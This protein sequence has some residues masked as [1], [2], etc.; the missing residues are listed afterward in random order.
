[1]LE[2][3]D[4]TAAPEESKEESKEETSVPVVEPEPGP[5]EPLPEPAQDGEVEAKTEVDE[6]KLCQ[7][8]EA[9]L[10]ASDHPLGSARLA[11]I[12]G[13]G[14]KSSHVRGAIALLNEQYASQGRSFSIQEMGGGVQMTTLPDFDD[15]IRRLRTEEK[16][17][18]LSE[19]ALDTLAVVA[20][21]QPALKADINHIRGVDSGALLRMLIEKGLVRI[22][23]RADQPG[24]PILYGTSKKFLDVFGLRSLRDLPKTDALG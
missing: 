9:L 6:A 4:K 10:F 24:R 18:R 14:A 23:G 3:K 12:F 8:V 5:S 1:L 15:W 13:S 20:Y 19:A 17:A 2:D 22:A 21:R 7:V 16:S 11:A